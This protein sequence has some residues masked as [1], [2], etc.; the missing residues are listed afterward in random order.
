MRVSYVGEYYE[1]LEDVIINAEKTAAVSHNHPEGIKGA[2]TT[3]VCVWMA[4]HKMMLY[5]KS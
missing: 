5:H 3:A 1:E 4:K 2:V